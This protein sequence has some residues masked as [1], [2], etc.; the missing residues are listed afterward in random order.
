MRVLLAVDSIITLD[1]LLNEAVARSWP[2]GT[3]AR[4]LS[5]VED[6]DVPDHVW[7]EMGYGVDALRHEMRRRGDQITILA[8]ERLRQ[9]GIP[10]EVVVMR[11]N[12]GFLITLEA[13]KWSADLILIR[14]HNRIDFKNWMLGSVAKSVS[15]NAPCSV[16][17]V[18]SPGADQA[19][20]KN[21]TRI[22]L[23]TDGS[24]SSNEA[25][26]TVAQAKW[27][28][29]TRVKVVS[30]VNP[31]L[32]ALE[33][34]GLG[35]SARTDRAHRAI[36]EAVQILKQTPVAIT[37]EVIAGRPAQRIID[38][39]KAWGANLIVVGAHGLPGPSRSFSRGVSEI[40]ATR[41]HCSVK[42]IRRRDSSE[43]DQLA[44]DRA[45]SVQKGRTVYEQ[46][47]NREWRPA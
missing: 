38:E 25:A 33:K 41:A 18:R 26:R 21:P 11:G 19:L 23:A 1:V 37:A 31:I 9:L 46:S 36:G 5:V 40:V 35:L 3:Q 20:A 7:R 4:V 14:A 2:A 6:A 22:L 34:I 44:R 17:V 13:R 43:D 27:P 16:D 10:S 8:T 28:A 15:G 47:D 39:A 42:I 45:A 24:E 30:V 12:P 29:E 32:S